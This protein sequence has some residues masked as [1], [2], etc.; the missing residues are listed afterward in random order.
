MI[1]DWL[2]IAEVVTAIV[3]GGVIVEL[4]MSLY[5]RVQGGTANLT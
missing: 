4:L 1:M 2:R 3:I 5:R